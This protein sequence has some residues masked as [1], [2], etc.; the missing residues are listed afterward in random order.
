MRNAIL[1]GDVRETLRGVPDGV[2]H[3]WWVNSSAAP[4][5]CGIDYQSKAV[6]TKA[7][8]GDGADDCC[9]GRTE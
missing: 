3:L 5:S 7:P 2:V 6:N 4:K 8:K 9:R 1:V